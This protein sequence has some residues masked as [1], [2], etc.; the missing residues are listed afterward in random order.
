MA[1][2]GHL[3]SRNAPKNNRR[4]DLATIYAHTKYENNRFKFV[5]CRVHTR[6]CLRTR[7]RTRRGRGRGGR[8]TIADPIY[9]RLSS[10]GTMMPDIL[11]TCLMIQTYTC[12]VK[13]G[14]MLNIFSS[15]GL[16][17]NISA[18]TTLRKVAWLTFPLTLKCIYLKPIG[19]GRGVCW[20][21]EMPGFKSGLV[22]I[23]NLWPF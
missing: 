5:T 3:G 8:V 6:K 16:L 18:G 13:P 7:R 14:E 1:A 11:P 2:G 4:W 21:V 22:C 15:F 10:G 12:T 17:W 9:P 23:T 19:L 20:P